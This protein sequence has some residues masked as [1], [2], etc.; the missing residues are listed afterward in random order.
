MDDIDS[1][2]DVEKQISMLRVILHFHERASRVVAKGCP[3][4][5]LHDLPVVNQIVRMKATIANGE[6]EKIR[7]I[8]QAI[9]EQ[10]DKVETDY[11]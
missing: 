2:A 6:G 3:I 1:Y 7:A 9:D 11:L 5:V 8:S 4:V 10:M